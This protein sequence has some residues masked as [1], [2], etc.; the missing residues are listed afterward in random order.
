[1]IDLKRIKHVFII[2]FV[3][4]VL[5]GCSSSTNIQGEW[6]AV[7]SDGIVGVFDFNEDSTFSCT[8]GI[9]QNSGVYAVEDGVMELTYEGD[10][11]MFY[12]LDNSEKD[13]INLYSI[14]EEGNRDNREN[15]ELSSK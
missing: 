6:D 10:E 12:D 9:F 5:A 4:T 11:P 3:V 8:I 7:S 13:V 2:L 1:M 14:D 15:I